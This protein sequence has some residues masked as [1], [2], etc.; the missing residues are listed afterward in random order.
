MAA[1]YGE[2]DPDFPLGNISGVDCEDDHIL[3]RWRVMNAGPD[4]WMDDDSESVQGV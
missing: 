4:W 3:E 2:P 1:V